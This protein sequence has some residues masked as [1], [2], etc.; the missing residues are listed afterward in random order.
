MNTPSPRRGGCLRILAVVFVLGVVLVVL[1]WVFLLPRMVRGQIEAATG[2]PVALGG[3]SAN[4]FTG[5]VQVR[6][7]ALTNPAAFPDSRFFDLKEFVVDLNVGSLAGEEVEITRLVVDIPEVTVVTAPDGAVNVEVLR[8][9]VEERRAQ[10][11]QREPAEQPKF[12]IRELVLRLGTLRQV[13]LRG[14]QER[15]REVEVG[16]NRTLNDVRSGQ[17]ILNGLFTGRELLPLLRMMGENPRAG[18]LRDAAGRAAGD[19]VREAGEAAGGLLDQ[20]LPG[21]RTQEPKP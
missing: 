9:N 13:D 3:F 4:P 7:L 20:M 2:F 10:Q 14:G 1:G 12:V 19:A 5:H 18:A 16:L 15:V 6:D 21:A 11:E 8:R 17:D